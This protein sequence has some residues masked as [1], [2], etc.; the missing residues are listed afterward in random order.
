MRFVDTKPRCVLSPCSIRFS[1]EPA[2]ELWIDCLHND[3]SL[4]PCSGRN[5]LVVHSTMNIRKHVI[6]F[7]TFFKLYIKDPN[8]GQYYQ[9]AAVETIV[10]TV[11]K[12]FGE[13]KV[14]CLDVSYLK[15][16]SYFWKLCIRALFP[17]EKLSN[18]MF[19]SLLELF[20][21]SPINSRFEINK[22]V[23]LHLTIVNSAA[24]IRFT[25]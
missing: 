14:A 10:S 6:S 18:K 5:F 7:S 3:N 4:A 15:M 23:R 1:S 21:R 22:N 13:T 17:T 16:G 19:E 11:V 20:K 8:N 25:T 9:H 2:S 12:K 24:T